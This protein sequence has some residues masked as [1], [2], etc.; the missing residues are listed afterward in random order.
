MAMPL[1]AAQVASLVSTNIFNKAH[2]HG[3]LLLVGCL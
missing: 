3:G 1:L 2:G